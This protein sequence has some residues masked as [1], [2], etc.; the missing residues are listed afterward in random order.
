MSDA[1]AGTGGGTEEGETSADEHSPNAEGVWPL[2]W[3]KFLEDF[4]P[5]KKAK[6]NDGLQAPD[7]PPI[8]WADEP[9]AGTESML[10]A[11]RRRLEQAEARTE[12]QE[13]RADRLVQ[14]GLSLVALD[15][16]ILGYLAS[17]LQAR[18]ADLLWWV[19]G[20]AAPGLA[21]AFLGLCVIQ[22]V[23]VDRVGFVAPAEPGPTAV[24]EE[25]H[26][27]RHLAA[28]EARATQMANWTA[29][30]KVNEVLQARAWFSRGFAALVL[31]SATLVVVWA[32]GEPAEPT[33]K[34]P[35]ATCTTTTTTATTTS[36]P[37]ATTSSSTSTPATST[38]S[39]A[40][41]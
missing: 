39:P 24:L 33:S 37:S 12:K 4:K 28:Q 23:G 17:R 34:V 40:G 29:R 15:F 8:D 31:A 18:H 14:R 20:L 41:P 5:A 3:Q 32:Q 38:T 22:G 16:L 27:L 35:C 11:T 25:V 26:R 30:K 2:W 19:V 7:F 13:E 36:A 10:E 21:L 6:A 1:G 9:R